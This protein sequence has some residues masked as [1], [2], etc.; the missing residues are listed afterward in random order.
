ML[1]PGS[2]SR[3]FQLIGEEV[4]GNSPQTQKSSNPQTPKILK[5]L[6]QAHANK[7]RQGKAPMVGAFIKIE[8]PLGNNARKNLTLQSINLSSQNFP[9]LSTPL[10]FQFT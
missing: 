3:H 4:D 2:L 7:A 9:I 5:H 8:I 6:L 1:I 10:F